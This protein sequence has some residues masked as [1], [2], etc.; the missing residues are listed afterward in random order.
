MSRNG[1]KWRFLI[2]NTYKVKRKRCH[3]NS[4]AA[5]GRS[6]VSILHDSAV[7]R[8]LFTPACDCS[9]VAGRPHLEALSSHLGVCED[10]LESRSSNG[11][12]W[13]SH[14]AALPPV[15]G[16]RDQRSLCCCSYAR[17][18]CTSSLPLLPSPLLAL[19]KQACCVSLH[20][21]LDKP[22][23]ISPAGSSKSPSQCLFGRFKDAEV[24]FKSLFCASWLVFTVR[25]QHQPRGCS[26][27][28]FQG[29]S[30][31]SSVFSSPPP[32]PPSYLLTSFSWI[33]QRISVQRGRP[34]V[35]RHENWHMA[36]G[37]L[38]LGDQVWGFWK[39][40]AFLEEWKPMEG[41]RLARDGHMGKQA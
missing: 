21:E 26:Q 12:T 4:P 37:N 18:I 24:V 25:F 13:S 38:P 28:P 40:S 15:L 39:M 10:H 27:L 29:V 16:L 9:R 5:S 31:A 20:Q 17:H 3:S 35:G 19:G 32:P 14:M 36:S 6:C 22:D 2:H 11:V 34:L 7:S 23:Q 30:Y 33:A 1:A 8:R 41:A